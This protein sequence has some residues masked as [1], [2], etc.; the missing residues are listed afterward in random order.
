[1]PATSRAQQEAIVIAEHSPSKLYSKNKGLLKM[2][3]E[4]MRDFAS[5]PKKNLPKKKGLIK[6]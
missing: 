4:D 6:D 3:H 1:M 5:T 2:S